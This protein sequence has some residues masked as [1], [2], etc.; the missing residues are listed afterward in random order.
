MSKLKLIL[1]NDMEF[2]NLNLYSIALGRKFK[3]LLLWLY[4]YMF[5]T[6]KSRLWKPRLHDFLLTIFF[7]KIF[8]ARSLDR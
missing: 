6:T 1:E 7:L 8:Y 4:L 5:N 2:Q 3:L